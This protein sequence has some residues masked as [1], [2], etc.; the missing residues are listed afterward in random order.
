MLQRLATATMSR[1]FGALETSPATTATTTTTRL[2]RCSRSNR[3]HVTSSSSSSSSSSAATG[4]TGVLTSSRAKAVQVCCRAVPS[5]SLASRHFA[6]ST[7]S[8]PTNEGEIARD[9][10]SSSLNSIN[11]SSNSSGD[12]TRE[13]KDA[14]PTSV[15]STTT[16]RA[17]REHAANDDGDKQASPAIDS[18]DPAFSTRAKWIYPLFAIGVI[19]YSIFWARFALKDRSTC[20]WAVLSCA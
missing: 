6:S 9:A 16:R 7:P 3:A 18:I 2:A 8:Q 17:E 1:C 13:T 19:A 20:S 4:T 14:S 12:A 15:D 10:S 5:P 11:S